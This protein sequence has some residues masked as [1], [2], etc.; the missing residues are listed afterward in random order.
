MKR[1]FIVTCSAFLLSLTGCQSQDKTATETSVETSEEETTTTVDNSHWLPVTKS[2]N[3]TLLFDRFYGRIVRYD[4]NKFTVDSDSAIVSS[5]YAFNN[6]DTNI[7]TSLTDRNTTA[8]IRISE[9]D[10][11]VLFE[12]NTNE[13]LLPLAYVDEE[14]MYI[15]KTTADNNGK[16]LFED[17]VICKFNAK[18]KQLEEIGST[19]GLSTCFGTVVGDDLYFTVN[20]DVGDDRFFDLYKLNTTTD[21]K[22]EL[23]NARLTAGEVYNYNDKLFVSDPLSIYGYEDNNNTFTKYSLNYFVDNYLFQVDK[24]EDMTLTVLDTTTKKV[25]KTFEKAVDF[26]VHENVATVY[27]TSGI[28]TFELAKK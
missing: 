18:T 9:K 2:E 11:E 20:E 13:Y 27:T 19:R 8:I 14:S 5:Q 15:L 3:E 21:E 12:S 1:F 17:R 28:E 25:V 22:P 23:L 16:E 4:T 26:K 6:L 7:Y 10:P 24:K